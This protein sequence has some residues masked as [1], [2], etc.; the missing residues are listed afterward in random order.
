MR[1]KKE[2][3]ETPSQ[4]RKRKAREYIRSVYEDLKED[5]PKKYILEIVQKKLG[6]SENT[7]RKYLKQ[8][9]NNETVDVV[10]GTYTCDSKLT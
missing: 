9:I 4:M 7:A 10:Y 3:K 1:R 8:S 6:I 5:Y 2:K